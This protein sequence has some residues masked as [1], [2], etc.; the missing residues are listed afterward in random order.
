MPI[1][2]S[3]I[4]IHF[5]FL[6][7]MHALHLSQESQGPSYHYYHHVR[8]SICHPIYT[9]IFTGLRQIMYIK[10]SKIFQTVEI[11]NDM[12]KK[13]FLRSTTTLNEYKPELN[14][15]NTHIEKTF[16]PL[17][18]LLCYINVSRKKI[19]FFKKLSAHIHH[20]NLCNVVAFVRLQML[21]WCISNDVW[22]QYSGLG[23][24]DSVGRECREIIQNFKKI[25][26]KPNVQVSFVFYFEKIR[27]NIHLI[28]PFSFQ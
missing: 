22:Q 14:Q 26:K 28:L 25:N 7:F 21:Q 11:S 23:Y 2:K 4:L 24:S 27:K 5:L 20:V 12:Q 10:L 19:K 17:Y 9:K 6:Y 15:A 18:P 1:L 3:S 8:I 13:D 16:L